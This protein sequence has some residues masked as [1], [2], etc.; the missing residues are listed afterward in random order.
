M[1]D[2]LIT[3]L[4]AMKNKILPD[5]IGKYYDMINPIRRI[6]DSHGCDHFGRSRSIDHIPS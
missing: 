2:K 3:T 6:P 5:S 1:K 4:I